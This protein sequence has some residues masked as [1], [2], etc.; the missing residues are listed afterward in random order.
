MLSALHLLQTSDEQAGTRVKLRP[1][2]ALSL[3]R[4]DTNRYDEK[5][6]LLQERTRS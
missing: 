5:E 6:K 1:L 3:T 4:S 2:A